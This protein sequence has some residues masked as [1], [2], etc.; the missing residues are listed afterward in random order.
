MNAGQKRMPRQQNQVRS[1][2]GYFTKGTRQYEEYF[3]CDGWKSE[4]KSIQKILNHL[5]RRI[6]SE[7]T[8][9][10]YLIWIWRYCKFVDKDPD[11][12]MKQKPAWL[13]ETIQ[14]FVDQAGA[15]SPTNAN[16]GRAALTA[17]LKVNGYDGSEKK[18]IQIKGFYQPS[19]KAMDMVE[20]IPTK[21][22][23][24]RMCNTGR[25]NN[26]RDRA[27]I[28]C[29]YTSGIRQSTMRA[30]RYKDIK[31]EYESGTVPLKIPVY[32]EMKEVVPQACKGNIPY[33]TFITQEAYD[34][35]KTYLDWLEDNGCKIGDE[36]FVFNG[37]WR[38]RFLREAR[39]PLSRASVD[40]LVKLAAKRAGIERWKDVHPHC[41]RAC[42]ESQPE[43][44]IFQS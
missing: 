5:A 38:N 22:E 12:V 9:D 28:L 40:A 43:G 41:L 23:I 33:Y 17:F 32:P 37:W 7:G 24:Y 11:E 19:R 8:R 31:A 15:V 30:L 26:N 39:T 10:C 36:D 6:K 18:V 2:A 1:V 13:K 25:Y 21:E 29:L 14:N 3:K 42:L 16:A 44:L 20:Y 34:A 4:Y 35:L 27:L